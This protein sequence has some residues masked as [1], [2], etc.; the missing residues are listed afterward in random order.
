MRSECALAHTKHSLGG[1]TAGFGCLSTH[2]MKCRRP[3]CAADVA[4][5]LFPPMH[6]VTGLQIRCDA[7]RETTAPIKGVNIEPCNKG[8][9]TLISKM[10]GHC[11]L[12]SFTGG[13]FPP[14]LIKCHCAKCVHE[15]FCLRVNA[16]SVIPSL[17]SLLFRIISQGRGAAGV[18]R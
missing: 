15:S 7:L 14:S 3:C 18:T 6:K 11:V 12:F 13:F 10:C 9:I 5:R 17:S 16:L 2:I 4:V 1:W 8:N